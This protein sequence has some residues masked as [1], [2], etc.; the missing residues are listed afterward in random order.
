[1]LKCSDADTAAAQMRAAFP[2]VKRIQQAAS[3]VGSTNEEL[4][5]AAGFDIIHIATPRFANHYRVTHAD[6]ADGFSDE[7]LARLSQAFIDTTG[8]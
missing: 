6:G 7:N 4:I 8:H 5:R 2:T 3:R 1:M